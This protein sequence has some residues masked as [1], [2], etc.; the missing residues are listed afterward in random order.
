MYTGAEIP[1]GTRL[2]VMGERFA[3]S[4]R[5]ADVM[6]TRIVPIIGMVYRIS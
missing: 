3:G 1:I 6:P 2:R 5:T 4:C